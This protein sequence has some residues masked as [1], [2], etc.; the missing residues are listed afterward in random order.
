MSTP[1]ISI[2]IPTY[3]RANLFAK[4]LDSIVIQSFRD[5]EIIVTDNSDDD[6]VQLVAESYQAQLPLQYVRNNPSVSPAQNCNKV[7]GLAKAPWIKLMHDDDWFATGDALQLFADAAKNSGKH[8]IF[9]ASNHVYLDTNK[10]EPEM[11]EG[12]RQRMFT[13]SHYALFYLN[14][15]GHPSVVMHKK[16]Q[17]IQYDEQF[18]WVQDIDFYLRFHAVH[19][20]FE[21]LPQALV[22]IGKGATQE[23]NKYYKNPLV[24]LP[25]YFRLLEKYPNE[26]PLKNQYVFHLVWN[27]MRRYKIKN[28]EGIRTLGFTG[29]IPAGTEA[30]ISYQKKIPRIILKQTPWGHGFMSRLFRRLSTGYSG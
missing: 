13:D 1:F 22:N 21:Y 6:A 23:S 19:G 8:F 11:L 25:E 29:A 24:E 18:N 7:M 15:V 16:D 30:I 5:F 4:L 3:K 2:C 12:K 20:A 10:S 27:M 17:A 28:I 9:C 14:L 26:L